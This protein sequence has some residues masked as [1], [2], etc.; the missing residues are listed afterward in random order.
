MR[1]K[2]GLIGGGNIGATLAHL[3]LQRNLGDVVLVDIA[4]GV[5]QGKALDLYQ[6]AAID[7]LNGHIVGTQDYSALKGADAV[8]VTAGVPRKP[9]MSRDDLL[10]INSQIIK[11]IGQQIRQHCPKAF[12]VVVTNPLDAMVWLMQKS[13][14]LPTHQVVGMA[15]IL[16]SGRFR[17]FLAV[18]LGV[19]VQDVKTFVLGGH[20]DNMV[21]LPRHTTVAGIPL[22]TWI[23]QGKL[24]SQQLDDMIKRTQNGGAEIVN[25]MKTGS[26]YYAP[27][28]AALQ[29]VEAYLFDEKRIL[30]CAA[31]LNGEYGVKDIYAGVPVMIGAGGAEKV[32]ELDLN[33]VEKQQFEASVSSVQKL[34][35]DLK[36]LGF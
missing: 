6:A 16:D 17:H 3:I 10:Q 21:A 34:V 25:L 26:A 20:G 12:V 4:E 5:T 14:G 2:I 32:I 15:G 35:D 11:E 22:Q 8:V 13:S 23:D 31:F 7:D 24:S 19:A 29:M 30:P 27:A 9:G 18:A 36:A 1:K 33:A 28:S